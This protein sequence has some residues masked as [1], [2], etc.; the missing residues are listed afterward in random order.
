MPYSYRNTGGVLI[1]L[2]YATEIECAKQWTEWN[3]YGLADT[4]PDRI[5]FATAQAVNRRDRGVGTHLI[6]TF[7]SDLWESRGSPWLG[8]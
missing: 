6:I 1:S 2:L 3:T 8:L 4:M 5:L 7:I